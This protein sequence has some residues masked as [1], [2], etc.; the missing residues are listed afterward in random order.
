M[1]HF[2][3]KPPESKK[4]SVPEREADGFVFLG[5]TAEE[6]RVATRGKSSEVEGNQPLETGK[7]NSSSVTVADS[8]TG[9]KAGQ[10]LENSSFMA[11]LLSDVPFTLAPHVLAVQGPISDLPDHLLS[12]DVSE[13]LSRFWYDFSLE[14]SVLCDS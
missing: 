9:N 3:R 1:F 11:E 4:P 7:E 6:E 8:E 13:N 10:T 12:Y 14:N 2:F 5:D